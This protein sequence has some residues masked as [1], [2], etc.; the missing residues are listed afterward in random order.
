MIR[1]IHTDFNPFAFRDGT[2]QTYLDFIKIDVD[3][4]FAVGTDLGHLPVEIDRV[5]ATGTTGND[6]TD[7]FCFLLHFKLSFLNCS[8]LSYFKELGGFCNR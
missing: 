3:Y 7:D 4:F 1:S 8:K 6:N 5:T 2:V